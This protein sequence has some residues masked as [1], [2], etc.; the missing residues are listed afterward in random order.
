MAQLDALRRR[1][2]GLDPNVRA[3]LGSMTAG[4]LFIVLNSIMRGL[5]RQLDPY[6]VQFLRYL[7]GVVKPMAVVSAMVMCG[8]AMNHSTRPPCTNWPPMLRGR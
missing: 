4:L 5:A 1:L 8:M 6:E 7:M 3:L 2:A